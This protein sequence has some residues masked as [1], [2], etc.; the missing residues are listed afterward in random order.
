MDFL[1]LNSLRGKKVLV[2][3]VDQSGT[4]CL[5][6]ESQVY[7]L[8]AGITDD[9]NVFGVWATETES[10]AILLAKKN[11]AKFSITKL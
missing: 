3:A 5:E 7:I 8:Y 1:E 10:E 9:A 2:T 4:R 11:D 6:I